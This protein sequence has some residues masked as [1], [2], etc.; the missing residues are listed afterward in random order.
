MR[1]TDLLF[2]YTCE[3]PTDTPNKNQWYWRLK[4]YNQKGNETYYSIAITVEPVGKYEWSILSIVSSSLTKTTNLVKEN[5]IC[6]SPI[7]SIRLFTIN[8]YAT[9]WTK[10]NIIKE[11]VHML[12]LSILLYSM[13]LYDA[14]DYYI[15]FTV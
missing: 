1:P 14:C 6:N 13:H 2:D 4:M 12:L 15:I 3:F 10:Y 7:T 8:I 5:S 9:T 11:K